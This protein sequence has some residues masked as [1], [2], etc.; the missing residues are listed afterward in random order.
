MSPAVPASGWALRERT[1]ASGQA[2]SPR[3]AGRNS[4]GAEVRPPRNPEL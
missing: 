1:G 2:L 3:E 4:T